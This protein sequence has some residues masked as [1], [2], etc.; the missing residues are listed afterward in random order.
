MR[1]FFIIILLLI[2]ANQLQAK[3]KVEN[4]FNFKLSEFENLSP[5]IIKFYEKKKLLIVSE[6]R[7]N[8][9]LFFNFDGY[10][11]LTLKKKIK[12][13]SK[14]INSLD[15]CQ[16]KNILAVAIDQK[17]KIYSKGIVLIYDLDNF[18]ILKQIVAGYNP[19]MLTFSKE[20]DY[21]FVA[22]EGE[23]NY[24]IQENPYGSLSIINLN[25]KNQKIAST[26]LKEFFFDSSIKLIGNVFSKEIIKN[27]YVNFE[28]EYIALDENNF[29]AYISLQENNAIAVFDYKLNKFLY[30]KSLGL[31]SYSNCSIDLEN[32]KSYSPIKSEKIFSTYEP[33]GI[34][35]Y[36]KKG[37][38]LIFTA[39]EGEI[40][41]NKETGY[42][43][44]KKDFLKLK[45]R[46]TKKFKTHKSL[47][48]NKK[49]LFGSRSFSILNSNLNLIWDSCDEIERKVYYK[50]N[51]LHNSSKKNLR[52]DTSSSNNGPAPESI[53]V[54]EIFNKIFIFITLENSG[55]VMVYDFS[56]EYPI[57]QDYLTFKSKKGDNLYGLGP[58]GL[59]LININNEVFFLVI[60]NE[61][62]GDLSFFKITGSF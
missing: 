52:F 8:E 21:L 27:K 6:N 17:Q 23:P 32:D 56:G 34:F 13:Y 9:I 16:K 10:K 43:N 47:N 7:N 53:I 51:F 58:E 1:F 39:N 29:R 12:T 59:E 35:Y 18:K 46:N 30:V 44:F 3:I 33:D 40:I 14:S 54:K 28:P 15:V 55:G 50:N 62:S 49:V 61:A 42:K 31:K 22:N 11:S 48:L 5:E 26:T 20:C 37:T 57:F 25:F 2:T 38:S 45:N 24:K 60:A 19:D 4:F 36:N 41:N